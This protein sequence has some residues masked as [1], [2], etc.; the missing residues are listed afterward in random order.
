MHPFK[1]TKMRSPLSILTL[2]GLWS[3]ACSAPN[4][5]TESF[6]MATCGFWED[7]MGVGGYNRTSNLLYHKVAIPAGGGSPDVVVNLTAPFDPAI[8]VFSGFWDGQVKDILIPTA[9][10]PTGSVFHVE[11][12]KG[13]ERCACCPGIEGC[14]DDFMM[15]KIGNAT[16]E[17]REFPCWQYH[18][19]STVW[20]PPSISHPKEAV[21]G[22][23]LG[24]YRCGNYQHD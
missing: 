19:G 22:T 21:R 1:R 5:S 7:I 14:G 12:M 11:I 13:A 24:W 17:G 10:N 15:K 2:S 4:N 3:L 6:T 16:F 18:W 23:C 20:A 8:G 9:S